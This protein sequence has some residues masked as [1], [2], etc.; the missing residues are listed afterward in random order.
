MIYIWLYA[1]L[2]AIWKV[3]V[4]YFGIFGVNDKWA[5]KF[6]FGMYE[7]LLT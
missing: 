7:P 3:I 2:Y 1:P 5:K 4:D 6:K